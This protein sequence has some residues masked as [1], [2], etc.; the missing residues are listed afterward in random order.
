MQSR[1]V[2]DSIV[3]ALMKSIARMI[4]TTV[5]VLAMATPTTGG[6]KM[7]VGWLEKARISPGNLLVRAKLDTGAKT[8][9]LGVHSLAEFT[10]HGESWVRFDVK[11]KY[12]DKITLEKKVQ[13]LVRI[14]RH[15]GELQNRPVVLLG[16]CLGYLYKEIEVNLVDRTDFNYPM[17][18]ARS[19]MAGSFIVD[20]SAKFTSP[21]S[22]TESQ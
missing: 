12:G 17:L 13:R 8:C 19:F 7:V 9:S 22:C 18:I 15:G 5:I 20:P 16:M 21:P 6:G 3:G 10:R 14:K 11:N 4:C 1:S 2:W